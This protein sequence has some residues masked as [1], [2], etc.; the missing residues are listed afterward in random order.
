MNTRLLSLATS[1]LLS[2]GGGAMAQAAANPDANQAAASPLPSS[3]VGRWLYDSQGNIIG[4]VRSLTDDGGTAVIMVGSYFQPGSHQAK[5]SSSSLS[6]LDGKVTL[7]S[8]TVDAL[9]TAARR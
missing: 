7:Q 9:N 4:S 1:L 2:I 3:A 8:A 5:I 6:I